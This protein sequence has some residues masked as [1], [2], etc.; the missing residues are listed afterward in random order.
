MTRAQDLQK[1]T[2]R[3]AQAD[4]AFYI[5]PA[6]ML[7]LVAGTIAQREIGLY[8]AQKIFFKSFILWAGPMPLPG[9]YTLTGLLT[10]FLL[11][12]FLLASPWKLEKAGI[13]LTHLGVLVLL[14]GGLATALNAREGYMLLPEGGSSPY[15]YDYLQRELFIFK[16]NELLLTV[17]FEK[18]E[19]AEFPPLPFTI[20]TTE[21]CA[22]CEIVK[23]ENPTAQHKGMAR[24]MALT[25][26]PSEKEPE[27]NISG[28]TLDIDGNIYIAFEAMP[29]PIEIKNY[30]IMFGRQQRLLPFS[31]K[32][33][34]FTK[35]NY[36]GTDKAREFSS[37]ITI[38]DNGISW[39]EHIAMNEP[40]R[41]KGYTFYQSSFE[42]GPDGE[43]TVLSVVENKGRLFP[44]IGTILMAAG[45]LLHIFLMM[46]AKTK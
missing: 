24:F 28:T 44:Y 5:L 23:Q 29:K 22:N 30:K 37:D 7:E 9:F 31:I 42:Q 19:Y 45:L 27:E 43:A 10:F 38:E 8:A 36:P 32:L 40:L 33:D 35:D 1:I 13:H 16:D 25:P 46:K 20:R 12:K 2:T 3:L 17:P 34:D 15:V 6:I 39:T 4:I 14:I 18:L 26:K 41:Y 21:T 11:L